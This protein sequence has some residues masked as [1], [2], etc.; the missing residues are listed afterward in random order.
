MN[1]SRKAR[2]RAYFG[3]RKRGPLAHPR[4]VCSSRT[5]MHLSRPGRD[6]SPR[7]ATAVFSL[8]HEPTANL[9]GDFATVT[10]WTRNGG[11]SPTSRY[12]FEH[13]VLSPAP[14][15][16]CR[17]RSNKFLSLGQALTF[18]PNWSVAHPKLAQLRDFLT[19]RKPDRHFIQTDPHRKTGPA[20][21]RESELLSSS[22]ARK[23]GAPCT[24]ETLQKDG[25]SATGP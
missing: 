8:G 11:R 6:A 15:G 12:S 20:E 18:R 17:T 7:R 13:I 16:G 25:A 10:R 4:R 1:S 5:S 22:Q 3:D 23:M 19:L 14:A 21:S 9:L 24:P 2:S